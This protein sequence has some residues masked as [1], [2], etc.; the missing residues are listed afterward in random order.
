MAWSLDGVSQ[1]PAG[2]GLAPGRQAANAR[3]RNFDIDTAGE[4]YLH[5]FV[6]TVTFTDGTQTVF[7]YDD[8]VLIEEGSLYQKYLYFDTAPAESGPRPTDYYEFVAGGGPACANGMDD[9]GDGLSDFPADPGCDSAADEDETSALLP[10]DDGIDN[11]GDGLV[12][13]GADPGCGHP[14]WAIEDPECD[15]GIDNDGDGLVD[16]PADPGCA[17]ASRIEAPQCDDGIDNDGDGQ[18]DLADPNC[19]LASD[20]RERPYTFSCGIGIELGVVIPLL[21][22]WARRRRALGHTPRR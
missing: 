20:G 22:A 9:D 11:D 1:A 13:F 21:A 19:S 2:V 17:A 3:D 18:V 15:D 12:D 7:T 6:F 8:D 5:G 10:C 14:R 4:T 16:Y